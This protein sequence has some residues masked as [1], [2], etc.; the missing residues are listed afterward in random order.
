MI[1][2]SHNHN[3]EIKPRRRIDK[4]VNQF[5]AID[6]ENAKEAGAIAFMARAMITATLPH[7]KPAGNIFIR[8]NG[9][10]TL[11]MKAD[12]Q[13]GLPYGS[14]PRLLLAWMTKE[15]KKT[16]S[17]ELYLGK[18]FSEFL[19]TLELSQSGGKRGDATRL[20][21]QMLRLFTTHIS[22][23]YKNEKE[24][25]CRGDNFLVAKSFELWWD[26]IK[27]DK[28]DILTH[29]KITLARDFFEELVEKPIPV[30]FRVLQALRRSPLQID[31]YVW[32]TY[33]FFNLKRSTLISWPH[34][35]NQF[36][37]DYAASAMGCRDFKKNFLKA[38]H[39]VKIIY[40]A[41]NCD[42]QEEGLMLHPSQTHIP[43][44]NQKETRSKVGCG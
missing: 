32:L 42:I 7:R 13:F 40:H 36:G 41:A 22:C 3:K 24:G 35:K 30:D 34:L 19:T 14:L 5:L 17:S 8:K 21:L 6:A 15:A 18:T 12:P 11:T 25:V 28:S 16:N 29:S 26:P 20:R 44:K 37:S 31:I 27:S 23:V 9:N 10:L 33:R 1:E 4:L 43:L 38:L 2:D 39:V